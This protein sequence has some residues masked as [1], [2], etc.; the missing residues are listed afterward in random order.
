M[1]LQHVMLSDTSPLLPLNAATWLVLT[2]PLQTIE[3][4]KGL[5]PVTGSV[6]GP[7][8]GGR[9]RLATDIANHADCY[10]AVMK[11]NRLV[12]PL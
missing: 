1:L 9:R 6:S 2:L 12:F 3:G 4:I 7:E 10:A 11:R 5:V 8:C